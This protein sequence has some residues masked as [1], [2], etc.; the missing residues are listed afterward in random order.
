MGVL[1][2]PANSRWKTPQGMAVVRPEAF[3]FTDVKYAPPRY[4]HVRE[5]RA[6]HVVAF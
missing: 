4:A 3:R 6:V 5:E 1:A 2:L